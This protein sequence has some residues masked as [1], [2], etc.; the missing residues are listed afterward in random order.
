VIV[1]TKGAEDRGR[2]ADLVGPVAVRVC[3]Q[4]DRARLRAAERGRSEEGTT[5]VGRVPTRIASAVNPCRCRS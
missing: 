3:L 2:E 5:A 1:A 4:T